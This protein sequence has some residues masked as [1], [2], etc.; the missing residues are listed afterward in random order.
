MSG[1][2]TAHSPSGSRQVSMIHPPTPTPYLN[3]QGI[4]MVGSERA[5]V[6]LP[7]KTPERDAGEGSLPHHR[8]LLLIARAG[9]ENVVNEAEALNGEVGE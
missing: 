9:S 5:N 2:I 7:Q 4:P 6:E 1:A 3:A 8:I